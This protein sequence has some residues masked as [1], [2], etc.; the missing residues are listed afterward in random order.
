MSQFRENLKKA[1]GSIVFLLGITLAFGTV[2]GLESWNPSNTAKLNT[3]ANKIQF[4]EKEDLPL[5][6]RRSL[7]ATE[8]EMA[9]VAW[10]YF[11]NNTDDN[12][13]LVNSVDGYTASTLWDTASYLLALIS[14]RDLDLNWQ[15]SGAV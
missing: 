8:L 2:F 7:T 10:T 5:R 11:Q 9:K 6:D 12:T 13:G 3:I 14:A 15:N 4:V 1:R